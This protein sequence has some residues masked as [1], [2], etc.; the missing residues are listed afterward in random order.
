MVNKKLPHEIK[1]EETKNKIFT[2]VESM[3]SEYDFKYLTVRNICEEAQVAYGSFYHH[4]LNKENLLFIYTN[5]LFIDNLEKNPYPEWLAPEDFIKHSLWYVAV[6]GH[7][8][9]AI[10]R[11]L[12]GYIHKNSPHSIFKATIDKEIRQILREAGEMGFLDELRN[13]MNRNA[14]EL[15][16]KDMEILC[17]GTL[18][19]WSSTEDELEPLHETLEHLCFNMLYSFSSDQYKHHD[20]PHFL[21]TEFPEF[22]GSISIQ[23][24]PIPKK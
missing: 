5:R 18:M 8:C 16:V 15:I 20:F 4:F 22:E 1:S 6:L 24:V 12:T 21:V 17:D 23:N 19:W 7:F 13:K 9:E 2:A 10:G 11:D 3:L 14:V